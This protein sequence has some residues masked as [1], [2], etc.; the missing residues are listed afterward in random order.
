[1]IAWMHLSVWWE[2]SR[3]T[4]FAVLTWI[5]DWIY[6]CFW[7]WCL[8]WHLSGQVEG[9]QVTA[10]KMPAAP[11]SSLRRILRQYNF[12]LNGTYA[13]ERTAFFPPIRKGV[14]KYWGVSLICFQELSLVICTWVESKRFQ[15]QSKPTLFKM[16]VIGG[17]CLLFFSMWR[18]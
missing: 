18:P 5:W 11:I 2:R 4:L 10:F 1:M 8:P 6:F 9:S 15:L 13:K 12:K 3:N 7:C 16:G 14:G 17:W